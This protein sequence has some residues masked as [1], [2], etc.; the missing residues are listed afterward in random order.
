M[1]LAHAE[2]LLSGVVLMLVD[3][4]SLDSSATSPDTAV[5]GIYTLHNYRLQRREEIFAPA[6]HLKESRSGF[7]GFSHFGSESV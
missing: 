7:G 1:C 6:L 2:L 3:G 5:P 4:S